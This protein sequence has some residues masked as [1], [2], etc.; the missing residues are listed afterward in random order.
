MQDRIVGVFDSKEKIMQYLRQLKEESR[1]L[2]PEV[3]LGVKCSDVPQFHRILL[4]ALC[5]SGR[6][7]ALE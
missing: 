3:A 1:D 7:R 5:S 2:V 4:K 6:R